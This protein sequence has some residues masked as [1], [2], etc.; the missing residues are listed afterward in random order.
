MKPK[1]EVDDHAEVPAPAPQAPEEVGITGFARTNDLPVGRDYRRA[2]EVV[3][4]QAVQADQVAD[5]AAEREPTD[6]RVAERSARRREPMPLTGGI[7]ILPERAAAARRGPRL[8]VD[9][10]TPH[11]AQVDHEAAVPDAVPRDAVAA[12]P[13]GDRKICLAG[14]RGGRDDVVDIE[15][16]DDQL[17]PSVDDAV[18]R[19]AC[20]VVARVGCGDDRA[21]VA[22]PES[23]QR[24][25]CHALRV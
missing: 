2:Q 6:A 1:R 3:Q 19:Q 9:R 22:L 7:E 4:G 14:E 25:L 5:P 8:G 21:A 12:T 17:R 18:E 15:R 16:S 11:Q 20:R 10:D 23:V 24:T 13:N